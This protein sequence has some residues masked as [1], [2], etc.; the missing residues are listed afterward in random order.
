MLQLA[1][2]LFGHAGDVRCLCV[3]SD[4]ESIVSGSRDRTARQWRKAPDYIAAASFEG[5]AWICSLLALDRMRCVCGDY[6][7][8]LRILD[9][10]MRVAL[11]LE[12]AHKG[13]IN[14]LA[15]LEGD[16]VASGAWDGT[17]KTWDLAT[18]VCLRT[19]SGHENAVCV[20]GLPDGRLLTGSVGLKTAQN[21]TTGF[22]LR[23]WGRASNDAPER[24]LEP[25]AGPI[26][27]VAL[28][29]ASELVASTSNDMT[30]RLYALADL[31]PVAVLP[32][33]AGSLDS[34]S[35]NYSVVGLQHGTQLAVAGEDRFL[36]VWD[37][38]RRVIVQQILHPCTVWQ[39]REAAAS[40]DVITAG[41]DGAVRVF[42]R[43][44]A[45]ALPS[46]SQTAFSEAAQQA[47]DALAAKVGGKVDAQSLCPIDAAPAGQSDM[48][49]RMFNKQGVAWVYQW[50]A[51]SQVWLEVGEVAGPTGDGPGGKSQLDGRWFDRVLPVE[52]ENQGRVVK[53]QLGFNNED[54]PHSVAS[55]FVKRHQLPDY[56]I[57]EIV[58]FIQQNRGTSVPTIG[59]AAPPSAAAAKTARSFPLAQPFT[60]DKGNLDG[61]LARVVASA[62]LSELDK[63][64]LSNLV[65]SLKS[66]LPAV[67]QPQID[68]LAGRPLTEWPLPERFPAL[69]LL[70]AVLC[71]VEGARRCGGGAGGQ[72]LFAK[73]IANA[74]DGAGPTRLMAL[75]CASNFFAW[76][77]CAPAALAALRSGQASLEGLQAEEPNVRVALAT[78]LANAGSAVAKGRRN[79][80]DSAVMGQVAR[81]CL[82]LLGADEAGKR[83]WTAL[84][85]VALFEP[86]LVPALDGAAAGG[87]EVLAVL[88]QGRAA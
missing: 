72:A 8:T 86:R 70:R 79:D 66:R 23:V 78:L 12:G 22:R 84:G 28:L 51:A 85:C 17:C 65:T 73:C 63:L 19:L 58:A 49:V 45:R 82:P 62:A 31:S 68:A 21:E 11:A 34:P 43:D 40:L 52:L 76:A 14:S 36:R 61:A 74:R 1:A 56:Y 25:H 13:Q 29:A 4:G 48:Q 71:T 5:P 18:G 41:S 60:F 54:N 24:V 75:R 38:E 20:L 32:N 6:A 69:D 7:G 27:D 80:A 3:L 64:Q 26:R 30:T 50:S 16:H 42:T 33:P 47:A 87:E 77:E 15:A 44:A 59:D 81:A 83:A 37:V 9:D 88:Q 10:A 2:E 39:V 35:W 57:P 53:L 46:A 67:T 55:E